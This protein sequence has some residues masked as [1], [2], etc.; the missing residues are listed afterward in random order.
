MIRKKLEHQTQ[1]AIIQYLT[2]KKVFFWRN[3]SGALKTERGGFIR[4]GAVGS[5]DI[6]V[7][8]N[9]TIFGIEVKSS[10]NGKL[11]P[12]QIAFGGAFEK[13]GGIYLVAKSVGD[14]IAYGL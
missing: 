14:I 1:S 11:S 13:A 5:P 9:G 6:F 3:N 12:N 4:F 7:I 2:L 8:K 10:I